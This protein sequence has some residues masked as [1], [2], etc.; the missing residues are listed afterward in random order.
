M[1]N[2]LL[3][4]YL[5][6]TSFYTQS[7]VNVQKIEGNWFIKEENN[8]T[9]KIYKAIDG[10]YYGK[11]LSCDKKEYIGKL[12]MRKLK[13]NETSKSYEGTM[14]EPNNSIVA[15][16]KLILVGDNQLKITASKFFISLD[17]LMKRVN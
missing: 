17:F 8:M 7:T 12:L 6:F 9:V 1:K 16:A 4:T 5:I 13:F 15:K 11:I 10:F 14:K 3:I 2:I